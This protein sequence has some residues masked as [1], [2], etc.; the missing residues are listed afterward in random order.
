MTTIPAPPP[1]PPVPRE[2]KLP[3]ELL[4]DDEFAGKYICQLLKQLYNHSQVQST[5]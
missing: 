2:Y 4:E 1:P 3:P 5:F